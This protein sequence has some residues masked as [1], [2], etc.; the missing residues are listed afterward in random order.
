MKLLFNPIFIA[1]ILKRTK[2]STLRREPPEG[3]KMHM[4]IECATPD[5]AV[6]ADAF[7]N[8]VETATLYTDGIG[9]LVAENP[10]YPHMDDFLW[11]IEGFPTQAEFN[12][13][14]LGHY[15]DLAT[16][17]ITFTLATFWHATVRPGHPL[18]ASASASEPAPSSNKKPAA[19]RQPLAASR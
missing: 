18:Y 1:P 5:G 19:S 9:E 6:F 11:Q 7:C 13:W 4:F 10:F 14:M 16:Q 17:A 2:R 8:G 15:P 12:R 3:L